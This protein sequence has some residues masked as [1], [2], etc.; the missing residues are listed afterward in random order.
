[1]SLIKL[2]KL[3]DN[4]EQLDYRGSVAIIKSF[5]NKHDEY[6]IIVELNGKNT[7]FIKKDEE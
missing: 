2:Q 1:M 4:K 3:I 7:V 6:E 5:D